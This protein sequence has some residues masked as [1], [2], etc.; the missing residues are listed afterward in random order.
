[1]LLNECARYPLTEPRGA[2]VACRR[3]AVQSP[4]C[5]DVEDDATKPLKPSSLAP[6]PRSVAATMPLPRCRSSFY[7]H[8]AFEAAAASHGTCALRARA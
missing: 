1:V 6:A 5:T 4:L 2:C 8:T 7:V 3:L